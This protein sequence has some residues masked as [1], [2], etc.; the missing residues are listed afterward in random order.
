M[1]I[2]IIN[3]QINIDLFFGNRKYLY[4]LTFVFQFKKLFMVEICSQ[5]KMR[6][7]NRKQTNFFICVIPLLVNFLF[8]LLISVIRL[9]I[10][11]LYFSYI[12]LFV[13]LLCSYDKHAEGYG[14]V[15]GK[16]TLLMLKSENPLTSCTEWFCLIR[17]NV[18]KKLHFP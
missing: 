17:Q 3:L 1:S 5:N 2:T 8:L 4:C 14:Y 9:P 15:H 7:L 16:D 13:L 12:C 11:T 18:L 10:L 6:T